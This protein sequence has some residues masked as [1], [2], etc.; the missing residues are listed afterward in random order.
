MGRARPLRLAC[1]AVAIR[2]RLCAARQKLRSGRQLVLD[3]S[4]GTLLLRVRLDG[5]SFQ[6]T[7]YTYSSPDPRTCTFTYLVHGEIGGSEMRWYGYEPMDR[8]PNTCRVTRTA[9]TTRT[10]RLAWGPPVPPSRPVLPP[11]IAEPTEPTRIEPKRQALAEDTSVDLGPAIKMVL[12]MVLAGALAVAVTRVLFRV[13]SRALRLPDLP[14]RSTTPE[15]SRFASPLPSRSGKWWG[16]RTDLMKSD[17]EF[18]AAHKQLLLERI[19]QHR[20]YGTLIRERIQL[21]TLLSE[22]WTVPSVINNPDP[23]AKSSDFTLSLDEISQM[24]EAM[25]IEPELR[26][27]HAH[28]H[29]ATPREDPMS[30][31]ARDFLDL[32]GDRHLVGLGK[33]GS[34]KSGLQRVVARAIALNLCE[35]M[36]FVDKHGEAV[37]DTAAWIANPS[38]RM[39]VQYTC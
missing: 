25:N 1:H 35:G 26:S 3:V 32:L 7:A 13:Q 4:S 9:Y 33:T 23:N 17:A 34:G 8:A 20:A 29:R 28:A 14:P 37:R 16:T 18:V 19:D 5:E 27:H 2:R 12:W 31:I 24:L 36:T 39:T 38:H 10:M 21:A 15:P 11:S 22:L 30:E 6:G